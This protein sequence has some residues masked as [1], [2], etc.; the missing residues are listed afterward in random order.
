[1]SEQDQEMLEQYIDLAQ[2]EFDTISQKL[3]ELAADNEEIVEAN[4]GIFTES[5]PYVTTGTVAF[6]TAFI[7]GTVTV[8]LQYI[9][10]SANV[11]YSGSHWGAGFGGGISAGGAI[12]TVPPRELLGNGAYS[13]V[14]ASTGISM[15]FWRER[16]YLGTFRGAALA[17]GAMAAGG[18]GKWEPG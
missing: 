16:T 5:R 3:Q 11:V 14:N 1:M 12:L 17:V 2:K 9:S 10:P 6:A 8:Q 15:Q 4:K 7:W 18:S 13:V